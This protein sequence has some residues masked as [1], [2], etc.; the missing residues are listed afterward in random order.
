MNNIYI[1]KGIQDRE[2]WPTKEVEGRRNRVF[3]FSETLEKLLALGGSEI[4]V[5]KSK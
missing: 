3:L 5:G 4:G 2:Y 1:G